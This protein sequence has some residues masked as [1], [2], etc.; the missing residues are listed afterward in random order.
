MLPPVFPAVFVE[1]HCPQVL[2]AR[3]WRQHFEKSKE[4]DESDNDYA[5][6]AFVSAGSGLKCENCQLFLTKPIQ[7]KS[8]NY[9]DAIK[10]YYRQSDLYYAWQKEQIAKE[11]ATLVNLGAGI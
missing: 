11:N 8:E 10:E 3:H 4:K 5:E 6:C 9:I 2:E 1:N 7:Y